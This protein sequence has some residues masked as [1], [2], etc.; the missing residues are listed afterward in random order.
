VAREIARD[1]LAEIPDYYTR[2]TKM[3]EQAKIEGDL[4]EEPEKTATFGL[5]Q[6]LPAPIELLSTVGGIYAGHGTGKSLAGEIA[7]AIAPKGKITRTEERARRAAIFASPVAGIAALALARKYNL[8]GRLSSVLARKAPRGLIT[9]PQVEQEGVRAITPFVTGLAGSVLGGLAT[10]TAAGLISRATSDSP[11]LKKKS[12]SFQSSEMLDQVLGALYVKYGP[13]FQKRAST[14]SYAYALDKTHLD[15]EAL[16]APFCKLASAS[17]LDPWVMASQ[18]VKGYDSIEK[19]ASG[20]P[21]KEQELASFYMTWSKSLVKSAG[22][23]SSI[24]G[25]QS[26]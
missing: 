17:G 9:S 24:A 25:D 6:E 26:E 1:H 3:E 21:S 15:K 7:A 13:S 23:L 20:P 11:G 16:G 10:G 12:A 4:R 19:T 18:V 5:D 2:L 8:G 14:G 22:V